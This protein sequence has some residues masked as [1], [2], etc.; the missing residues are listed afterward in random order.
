[1]VHMVT[2]GGR[3]CHGSIHVILH[4]LALKSGLWR[5]G[6]NAKKSPHT[7]CIF[8]CSGRRTRTPR[9][10]PR[11]ILRVPYASYPNAKRLSQ[12][13]T[14]KAKPP[15]R[16]GGAGGILRMHRLVS[17]ESG[18]PQTL[19]QYMLDSSVFFDH[20]KKRAQT[21]FGCGTCF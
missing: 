1:M 16:V 14:R 3:Q 4:G 20:S 19:H 10:P 5:N 2:Y 15:F 21:P 12:G 11:P 18:G 8:G 17:H 13:K 9:E 6:K 7:C